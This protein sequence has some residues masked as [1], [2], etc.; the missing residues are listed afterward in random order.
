MY[1][2]TQEAPVAM[3]QLVAHHLADQAESSMP[4]QP[5]AGLFCVGI[6]TLDYVYQLDMMPLRPE[7]HRAKALSVVGGGLA[8]NAAVAAA[9]LGGRVMMATRLG[10]DV[11][12]AQIAAEFAAEGLDCQYVRHLRGFSSPVSSIMVDN[13]GERLVVSYSDP[14]MPTDPSWLP[15]VLPDGIDA[16]CGDTRWPEGALKMLLVA[17]KAQKPAVLDGDR[18]V[19]ITLVEAATHVVFSEQGIRETTGISDPSD[20]LAAIGPMSQNWLA[21]T[22]GSRGMMHWSGHQI[23]H[24]ASFDVEVVDTLGAGDVWHG[25]FALALGEGRNEHSAIRF[26]NAAAALKCTRFG[27]RKGAPSRAEVNGFLKGEMS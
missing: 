21:V 15:D 4:A 8:A 27:G 1:P 10:D 6:S 22:L 20:A 16:I 7:K 25:A 23:V 14:A 24:T 9:R 11:A 5:N 18:K 19:D 2:F 17:R 3:C 12:G 13:A 26:A